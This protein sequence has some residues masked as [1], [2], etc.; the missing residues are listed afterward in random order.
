MR[1]ILTISL[2]LMFAFGFSQSRL[3]SLDTVT[4]GDVAYVYYG[5]TLLQRLHYLD[6]EI[7]IKV[8][9]IYRDGVLVRREWWRGDKMLS[10]T[11][12]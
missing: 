12:E 11:I 9:Y 1:F 5:K 3:D 2:M 6:S 4:T 7:D 10:Y 8:V